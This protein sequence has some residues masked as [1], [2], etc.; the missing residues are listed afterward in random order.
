MEVGSGESFVGAEERQVWVFGSKAGLCA[1]VDDAGSTAANAEGA[2][3]A[4][5][6][7][8]KL[9]VSSQ[10][11][12]GFN[13]TSSASSNSGGSNSNSNSNSKSY[14]NVSGSMCTSAIEI[15]ETV[16]NMDPL[17]HFISRNP[18]N[19]DRTLS[20]PVSPAQSRGDFGFPVISENKVL[21]DLEGF[22]EVLDCAEVAEEGI[23]GIRRREETSRTVVVSVTF[24][25]AS[26]R[27]TR[28]GVRRRR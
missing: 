23:G 28:L 14:T 1:S 24:R 18:R 21:E 16:S 6:N 2:G 4:D 5:K 20:V 26:L 7:D 15:Y 25:R 3:T 19:I 9:T 22:E 10:P 11:G 8:D 17:A 12:A 27:G 13:K